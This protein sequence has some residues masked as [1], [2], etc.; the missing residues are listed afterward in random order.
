MDIQFEKI[1]KVS[2][3]LT[4]NMVKAD[5][6]ANVNKALKDLG[7]KVQ[8]PGF[9]PGH[10]PASLV[11]KMYGIQ[12]KADEVN[13]LLQDTLFDYIKT[14]KLNI[15]GEP[16]GSE[17]QVPQDIEKQD[18]FTFIFDIALAPKFKAELS[19][20]DTIDYYDIE[21]SED[22]ITKQL[23][24]LQQ[25]AGHPE[26]VD[27]YEDRDILRGTLAELDENGQPKEGGI[28]V[29][30]ASLMPAY[31]KNDDQKK[32]FDDAK[33]NDVITFNPT[34]AYEANESELISLFKIERDDVKNHAGN[35]SFQVNEISRFVPAT[36]DQEFFD[37]VFGKDEVKSEED[38]RNKIKE[39]IQ[40]LQSNDSD[41]KFLLDV[42]A[43]MENKVGTLEFPDELLKK[44]MKANN[45]DKDEK[46][47]EDNYAKSIEELKWHLIKEQLVKANKIKVNDKDIKATAIQAAR[48]QFA[49]YGMNNI[50]DEYLE[51]YA[52]EMLKH[53][54]QVN[55]LV[56]RCV[57]QK[58]SEAL[59]SVV[60][61]NHKSISTEDFAKM[62][63]EKEEETKAEV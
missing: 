30:T 8:M 12:A 33:K 9:R 11:K 37:K 36:L 22:M 35:F 28:V 14:K 4:I 56:D 50:P 1:G 52:Q 54:E 23:G 40:G 58:L 3:E 60:K 45:K 49:Q 26:S 55:Q 18:D 6:E 38:A 27:S 62:F 7:K 61:L 17:K 51:N 57:D 59:K 24:A 25:Q 53:Q 46:F 20:E 32:I 42:R 39:S 16:L 2:G 5:Y 34:T 31:F 41:F 21:V 29:E 44:I 47:V 43:Y 19:E 10:V 63:E 48:F 13:K 15:L